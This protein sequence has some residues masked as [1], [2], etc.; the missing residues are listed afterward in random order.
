MFSKPKSPRNY[1]QKVKK[2]RA[3]VNSLTPLVN[4]L[5]SCSPLYLFS[6]TDQFSMRPFFS[7]F[8][9]KWSLINPTNP[10][11]ALHVSVQS[12]QKLLWLYISL[13]QMLWFPFGQ[14]LHNP[15]CTSCDNSHMTNFSKC[16][17]FLKEK[18]NRRPKIFNTTKPPFNLNFPTLSNNSVSRYIQLTIYLIFTYFYSI[19]LCLSK[20]LLCFQNHHDLASY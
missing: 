16:L 7:T 11:I 10:S 20:H 4:S 2:L 8:L 3:R 17:A 15:K 1:P 6:Q 5:Y 13:H 9:S 14:R 18:D 19:Q 12:F